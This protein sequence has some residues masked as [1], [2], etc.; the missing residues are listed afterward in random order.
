[1]TTPNDTGKWPEPGTLFV[2]RCIPKGIIPGLKIF[3][4]E[5]VW[6]GDIYPGGGENVADVTWIADTA[7]HGLAVLTCNPQIAHVSVEMDAVKTTGARIFCLSDSSMSTVATALVVGRH[8]FNIRR[9]LRKQGG[10][11]WELAPFQSPIRHYDS[12]D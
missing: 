2:D 1:M 6:I 4:W 10:F 9:R 5:A 7:R 3:G 12:R 11:F 8:Y